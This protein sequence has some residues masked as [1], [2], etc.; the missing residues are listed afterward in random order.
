MPGSFLR[1]G[2]LL[3]AREVISNLQLSVALAAQRSSKRRLGEILVDRGYATEEQI[4][5]CLAAQYGYGVV[6][7]SEVQPERD[8][9]QLVDPE[10][11]LTAELLPLRQ[12]GGVLECLI[13]DP[14]DISWTDRVARV[15]G[16]RLSLSI[17]P[18]TALVSAIR[19]WYRLDPEL[20]SGSAARGVPQLPERYQSVQSRFAIDGATL[21]GA[22]DSVLGREVSLLFIPD[23]SGENSNRADSIRWAAKATG[24]GLCA[25]HDWWEVEEG[26]WAVFER[27]TGE[28]LAN[29]LETRGPRV[30][31]QAADIVSEIAEGVDVLDVAGGKCGFVCPRN[32]VLLHSNRSVIAPLS[33]PP[34]SYI[35]PEVLNGEEWNSSADVF[36]LGVLLYHTAT[37]TN[38]FEYESIGETEA[39]MK[40]GP[41]WDVTPLPAAMVNI[42][43]RCLSADPSQ[44]YVSPLQLSLAL[45][46][47]DWPSTMHV[48]SRPTTVVAADREALLDSITSGY[49]PQERQTFWSK[50]FGRR[51]A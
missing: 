2:E 36:A 34:H 5:S 25:V 13:A 26:G 23:A 21:V 44:R 32:V 39:A 9:L 47:C 31:A 18:R 40:R 12:S 15:T 29:V 43:K 20:A 19:N 49:E 22:V 1:L 41:S 45:K 46:S 30:P 33:L 28:T 35:A 42:I 51:A 14:I 6:D 38:P 37:G 16:L 48:Q 27:L 3:V 10:I 17:S 8:A 11:A 24:P 4:A 7:P 50:L